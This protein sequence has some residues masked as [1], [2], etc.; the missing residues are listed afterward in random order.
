VI[1][2][3]AVPWYW[4]DDIAR[5]LVEQGRLTVESAAALLGAPVAVRRVE[6][7]LATAAQAMLDE[8]EI[9]IAA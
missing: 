4:T 5:A 6:T 3:F 7:D 9:P 8:D 1:W 2:R